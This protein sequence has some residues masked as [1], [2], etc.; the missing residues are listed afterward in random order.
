[1]WTG[2]LAGNPLHAAT[3]GKTVASALDG[4]SILTISGTSSINGDPGDNPVAAIVQAVVSPAPSASPAIAYS[5]DSSV[6]AIVATPVPVGSA[7]PQ[8]PSV[9][10][11]PS[12]NSS[13]HGKS[14]VAT[15]GPPVNTAATLNTITYRSM[16]LACGTP[17]ADENTAGVRWD[18]S[19]SAWVN[20]PDPALADFYMTYNAANCG[21]G[22]YSYWGLRSRQRWRR[23][24]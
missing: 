24:W 10:V 21:A 17:F 23:R 11:V 6:L 16:T 9:E 7:S 13:E 5:T 8:P 20:E 1:M 2:L 3:A 18:A 22:Y 14:I 12:P 15:V 4:G 19:T